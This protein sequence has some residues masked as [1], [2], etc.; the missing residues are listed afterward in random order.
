M[1]DPQPYEFDDNP[2]WTLND[3]AEARPAAEIHHAAI[4]SGLV[5]SQ[6]AG[7]EI[8]LELD[9]DVLAKFRA[10]GPGWQARVNDVLRAADPM[11]SRRDVA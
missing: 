7:E 3:F 4:V 8:A 5:R 11:A 9:A 10:T 2:E 1:D 6:A